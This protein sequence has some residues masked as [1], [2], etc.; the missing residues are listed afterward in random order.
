MIE[1]SHQV[2]NTIPVDQN[3]DPL[4]RLLRAR[5]Q[6]YRTAVHLQVAQL[7]AT[8]A[9]PLAGG[10]TGLWLPEWR[11][12]VAAAGLGLAALDVLFL[13][14]AMKRRLKDAA[15]ISEQFDIELLDLPWNGF[16]VGKRVDPQAVG[17][18]ATAW[19]N[20]DEGLRDW[21]GS[22][23]GRVP[24]DEARLICQRANLTY[25][26]GLRRF[27]SWLLAWFLAS[28]FVAVGVTAYMH[29]LVWTDAL[30]GIVLP[31]APLIVWS[32]RELFRQRDAAD[33]IEQV[34]GEADSFFDKILA[35]SIPAGDYKLRSREFQDAI[36]LR[37]SQNPL[38]A[39]GI[40]KLKRKSMEEGMHL[41]D[42][43]IIRR[44]RQ[45]RSPPAA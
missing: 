8:V 20:G 44:L 26:S 1:T 16:F 39:P 43:E 19:T 13:D 37:R 9:L 5:S 18:A 36:Y 38:I 29:G 15:K 23:V 14:R 10:F 12:T 3:T 32:I 35:G 24:H 41:A 25:D 28:V 42:E 31:L 17:A 27:Y 22:A 33:G 4:L 21:Y 40:Y 6:V 34:R 11:S 30:T 7:I 2:L 45:R